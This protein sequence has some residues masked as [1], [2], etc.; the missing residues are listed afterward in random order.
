[1]FSEENIKENFCEFDFNSESVQDEITETI[2]QNY[3]MNNKKNDLIMKKSRKNSKELFT[4]Y[5]GYNI[6][7]YD[8]NTSYFN[9][10]DCDEEKN[11]QKGFDNFFNLNK[12]S[13]SEDNDDLNNLLFLSMGKE[14]I[15]SENSCHDK[16]NISIPL[17]EQPSKINLLNKKRKIF[18][19]NSS[20]TQNKTTL[21][22]S[23]KI[24]FVTYNVIL[25]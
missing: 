5:N 12:N 1:M 7:Y 21:K 14:I 16:L 3:C 6:S 22:S 9:D 10:Y 18:Q 8:L 2:I 4:F 13:M 23:K 25:F 24:K 17:I 19:I 11:F 15:Q 20:S